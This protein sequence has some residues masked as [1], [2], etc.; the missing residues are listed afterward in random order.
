MEEKGLCSG[1]SKYLVSAVEVHVSVL[2][3]LCRD[4]VYMASEELA[5]GLQ[6]W[7]PQGR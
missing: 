1:A 3:V 5:G 6:V 7:G 2:R 4:R